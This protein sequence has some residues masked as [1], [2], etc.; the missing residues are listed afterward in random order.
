[1]NQSA[2]TPSDRLLD[3]AATPQ[4]AP[5]DQPAYRP[6]DPAPVAATPYGAPQP[7]APPAPV[8]SGWSA[9][10]ALMA[11]IPMIATGLFLA[12]GHW[13]FFLLIPIVTMFV[14]RGG[15]AGGRG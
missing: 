8:R 3:A 10:P 14:R 1:M 4:D 5:L 15:C 6:V 13:Q 11:G 12:T 2:S 7:A 9:F